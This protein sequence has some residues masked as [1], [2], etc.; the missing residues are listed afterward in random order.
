M[1][2]LSSQKRGRGFTLVELLVV[3]VIIGILSSLLLPAILNGIRTAKITAC[4]SN[5]RQLGQLGTV[6]ATSHKGNWPS[7]R[8]E[9]LWLSL[10]RM[11]PPLIE[12]DHVAVLA[13]PLKGE[14]LGPDETD[15]RGP[16]LPWSK[17][18]AADP[19]GADKVGNHGDLHG[20]N[21]LL[22]DGSV[23]VYE[24]SDPKWED[25]ATKLS[26]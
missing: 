25:C 14:E 5:L 12:G 3:I 7:A 21:V 13:C 23:Q 16:A 15:F 4:A 1:V 26:P 6:Y 18:G 19:M 9:E 2:A 24:K 10:R 8:G 20:G 17:I 11:V 22:R